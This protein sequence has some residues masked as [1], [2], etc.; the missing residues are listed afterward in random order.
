MTVGL[1][2]QVI[3]KYRVTREKVAVA[4]AKGKKPKYKIV[5]RK[6]PY[7]AGVRAFYGH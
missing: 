1:T 6:T 5:T 3:T 7:I 4:G 2:V